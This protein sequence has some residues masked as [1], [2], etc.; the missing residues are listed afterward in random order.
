[1]RNSKNELPKEEKEMKQNNEATKN[2]WNKIA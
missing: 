2:G 1:M